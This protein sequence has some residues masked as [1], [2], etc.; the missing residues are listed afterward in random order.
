MA[1]IFHITGRQQ[2]EDARV[3]GA[4]RGDTLDTEG[5]IHSSEAHQVLGVANV[6]FRGRTDL[7]LLCVDTARVRAPVRYDAAPNGQRYPHIYGPLNVDAVV[8][9]LAFPPN[10]DGTFTLPPEVA[11]AG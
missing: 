7:V 10:P 4:Y 9:V 3:R 6:I 2:W 1:T 11:P 8:R 5:F